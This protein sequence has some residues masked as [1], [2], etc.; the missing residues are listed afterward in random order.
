MSGR[1]RGF[2]PVELPE[3]LVE[4]AEE[5]IDVRQVRGRL[6][7]AG[8]TAIRRHGDDRRPDALRATGPG[9]D[10]LV[11]VNHDESKTPIVAALHELLEFLEGFGPLRQLHSATADMDQVAFVARELAKYRH[12]IGGDE[13]PLH[14]PYLLVEQVLETGLVVTYARP[15]TGH[16]R[17][18]DN[19]RPKDPTDRDLHDRLLKL[20]HDHAHADWTGSRT[21][22]DTTALLGLDGPMMLAEQ[23]S[24]LSRQQLLAMVDLAER[25]HDRFYEA[26]GELK[27]RVGAANA[28]PPGT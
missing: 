25:Q 19:W 15:F 14:N 28:P 11:D 23:R 12:M 21:L 3:W 22:V 2:P 4:L 20:R 9:L 17:L 6:T 27:R 26:A 5:E 8:V 16:A 18:G 10:L 7:H 1:G 13:E 24:E